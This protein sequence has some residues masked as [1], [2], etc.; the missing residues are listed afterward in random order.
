MH[1]LVL[2]FVL[3]SKHFPESLSFFKNVFLEHG[4]ILLPVVCRNRRQKINKGADR[5]LSTW[6]PLDLREA[7][8]APIVAGSH[9]SQ[10]H[11]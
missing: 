4:D 1:I 2:L 5:K 7:F 8:R 10:A 3:I 11:A 6:K 9:S